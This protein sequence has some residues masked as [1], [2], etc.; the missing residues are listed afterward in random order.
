MTCPECGSSRVDHEAPGPGEG[1]LFHL[2]CR[3]CGYEVSGIADPGHPDTGPGPGGPDGAGA[4]PDTGRR[5]PGPD[6]PGPATRD[7][8]RQ[9]DAQGARPDPAFTETRC[10][11]CGPVGRSP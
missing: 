10:S 8:S 9:Q 2:R 3:D 4:G 1:G 7:R 6:R 5:A 11:V